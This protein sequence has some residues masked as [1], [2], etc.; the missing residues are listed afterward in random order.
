MSLAT[1]IYRPVQHP[2]TASSFFPWCRGRSAIGLRLALA[3]LTGD[4]L[5]MA[6]SPPE[7]AQFAAHALQVFEQARKVHTAQ[8]TNSE[9]AWK[10]A[11]A[12]F[13]WAEFATNSTERADLAQQGITACRDVL[14]RDPKSAAAHY[15]LAMNLG[16]LARTR[17]LSALK[18]VNEMEKEFTLASSLDEHLDFAG[19][20]RN[21]GLLYRDAPSFGSIGSRSKARKHLTRATELAPDYPEN[22]L[23]LVESDVQWS[24]LN[25]ARRELKLLEDVLP[26]AR[27][28]LVG[29]DWASSWADWTPRFDEAKKKIEAPPKSLDAH[30]RN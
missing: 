12:C 8:P 14:A 9:A 7:E 28:N 25:S 23:S 11:R 6:A 20:D 16:Q 17:G 21:L 24:D 27:T 18:L 2:W 10:F 5:A 1:S 22:R 4:S 29:D 30:K 26:K 19:P 3:L 13:D 15:Y